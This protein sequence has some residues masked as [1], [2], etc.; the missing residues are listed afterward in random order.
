MVF[1]FLS[2]FKRVFKILRKLVTRIRRYKRRFRRKHS[3]YKFRKYKIRKISRYNVLVKKSYNNFF[4][5]A[6]SKF[7]G[8]VYAKIT[9]AASNL[10]GAKRATTTSLERI[11][12]IFIKDLILNKILKK[13]FDFVVKTPFVSRGVKNSIRTLVAFKKRVFVRS[14]RRAFFRKLKIRNIILDYNISHNGDK[15]AKAQTRLNRTS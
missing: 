5:T 8:E 10:K 12:P 3:F 11:S 6:F 7:E 9:G 4:L 15:T 14:K 2:Q 13:K 1:I